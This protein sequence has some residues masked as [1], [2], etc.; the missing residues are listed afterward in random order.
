VPADQGFYNHMS[1]AEIRARCPEF[2]SYRRFTVVRDPYDQIISFFHYK[3]VISQNKQGML[4][5][6]AQ[7]LYRRGMH[8][9]LRLRFAE[10]VQQGNLVDEKE[11]LCINGKLVVDRWLRFENLQADIASLVQDWNLPLSTDSLE[12]DL[13][14]FKIMR[15][16]TETQSPPPV[17][18]YLSAEA[19]A[20]I[21]KH[22]EW[23]LQAFGYEAKDPQAFPSL[24]A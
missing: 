16:H 22:R 9:D 17:D 24:R 19:L 10:F 7:E 6:D 3:P 2:D 21:N 5:S 1:A 18:A 12:T 20:S 14:R 4:L 23:H 15:H 13:P 11:R 8:Q